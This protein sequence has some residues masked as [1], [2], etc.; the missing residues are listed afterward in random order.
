MFSILRDLNLPFYDKKGCIARIYFW[1]NIMFIY[2][3]LH[4]LY[5]YTYGNE[6]NQTD[7]TGNNSLVITTGV[8]VH[9]FENY[10]ARLYGQYSHNG[11]LH[12]TCCVSVH[13]S[14]LI[15]FF[16]LGLLNLTMLIFPSLVRVTSPLEW[17]AGVWFSLSLDWVN[18][19]S[20][21]LKRDADVCRRAGL[22][23]A[24]DTNY[25][26]FQATFVHIC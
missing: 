11:R 20:R 1:Q 3:Y 5:N 16:L 17:V 9:C 12:Y 4:T 13:T 15:A 18:S 2:L 25:I 7:E 24:L 23:R 10:V 8:R 22:I 6:H 14:M 26:M 19:V 21:S